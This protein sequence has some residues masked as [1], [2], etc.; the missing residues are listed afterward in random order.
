[1]CRN[2]TNVD[3]KFASKKMSIVGNKNLDFLI[4]SYPPMTSEIKKIS[5]AIKFLKLLTYQKHFG[6]ILE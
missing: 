4:V 1:M 3:S 2:G 5:V 6:E